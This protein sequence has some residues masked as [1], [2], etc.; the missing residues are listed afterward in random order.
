[1]EP[2]VEHNFLEG[3]CSKSAIKKIRLAFA[4]NK[5]IGLHMSIS[6]VLNYHLGEHYIF[7]SSFSPLLFSFC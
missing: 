2:V 3:K 4:E 5:E 6:N 7:S 1:M